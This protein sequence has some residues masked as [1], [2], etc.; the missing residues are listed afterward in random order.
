MPENNG[1]F[2]YRPLLTEFT[3]RRGIGEAGVGTSLAPLVRHGSINGTY[4]K[5]DR[6][7]VGHVDPKRAPGEMVK[8]SRTSKGSMESF[9]MTDHSI[10]K[11]VP[12]E[13]VEGIAEPELFGELEQASYEALEEIQHSHEMA[14]YNLL[15]AESQSG[16]NA[17]YGSDA[18][19]SPTTKWGD[20]GANIY[21]NVMAKKE[22]IYKKCGKYPNVMFMTREVLNELQGDPNNE[23]GERIKYTNGDIPDL[24]LL[25]RYF[26]VN[27]IIVPDKLEDTNNAGAAEP[28]YD[29]MWNGDNVGLYYIDNANTRNK[30]TLAST[31]YADMPNEPFL[32]VFTKW[33]DDNKSY[34]VRVSGYFDTKA[35]DLGCGGI[36]YDVLG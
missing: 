15:W 28:N 25:A 8:Q 17:I 1:M 27:Q 19:T 20:S 29:Y 35:I 2:V 9:L 33:S 4:F 36:L 12:R 30:V 21:A 6:F 3:I 34:M 18:V 23:I 26:R 22:A 31:F 32:G 7:R 24:S 13:L 11:P 16:F 5:R 10:D 14:V